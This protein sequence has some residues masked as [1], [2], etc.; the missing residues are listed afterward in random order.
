MTLS[1]SMMWAAQQ[2]PAGAVRHI[3]R[4]SQKPV[5]YGR[6]EGASECIP[7]EC[8]GIA[9]GP[10]SAHQEKCYEPGRRQDADDGDRH[11]LRVPSELAPS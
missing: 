8:Q 1:L 3:W 10:C 6:F 5:S 9:Q 11:R 2:P 7:S 4:S